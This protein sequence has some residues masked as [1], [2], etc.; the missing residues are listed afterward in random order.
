MGKTS[1]IEWT[2]ATWNPWYGCRKVSAGCKLCYAERDMTRYGRD[3][4]KVTR[5]KP[6][7]FNAPLKWEDPLRIFTCSWSDFFIEQADQWRAEAWEIIRQTPQHTY[8]ILTKRPERIVDKDGVSRLPWMPN[9][10]TMMEKAY[11]IE[12]GIHPWPHVMM[13]A[14]VE[15]QPTADRRIPELLKIPAALRGVSYE[16]GLGPLTLTHWI[17]DS[18][19]QWVIV[20]GESARP[21]S[22]ARPFHLEW[23]FDAL[24]QC[25]AAPAPALRSGNGPGGVACFIKQLGSN[26]YYHGQPLRLRHWKGGDMAEWPEPLRVRELPQITQRP[27]IQSE[28]SADKP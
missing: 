2:D 22:K 9:S 8:M 14:S 27:Q 7:T 6:A 16:P 23:A 18:L 25:R 28:K 10:A 11:M 20:G 12:A 13:V 17:T 15:D 5:A 19:I 4:S 21:R 26:P 3:F 1:E 24:A